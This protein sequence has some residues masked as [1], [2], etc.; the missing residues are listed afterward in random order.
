MTLE[1]GQELR[2]QALPLF[3]DEALAH[4]SDAFQQKRGNFIIRTA[5]EK[6]NEML[7][8][9]LMP[10]GVDQ[11]RWVISIILKCFVL[12]AL[13]QDRVIIAEFVFLLKE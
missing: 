3:L 2:H 1:I 12:L 4:Q 10:L 7:L 8:K 9:D 13:G 5:H 11:V 6:R